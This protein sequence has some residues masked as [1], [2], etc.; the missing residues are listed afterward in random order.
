MSLKRCE[1]RFPT[2]AANLHDALGLR[3]GGTPD[4]PIVSPSGADRRL[5]RHLDCSDRNMAQVFSRDDFED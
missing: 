4:D 5:M 2:G 3:P 1:D